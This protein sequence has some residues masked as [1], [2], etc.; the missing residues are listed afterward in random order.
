VSAQHITSKNDLNGVVGG[1]SLA[2][3]EADSHSGDLV[4]RST[5][6]GGSLVDESLGEVNGELDVR[7]IFL[8]GDHVLHLEVA[9]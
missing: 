1:V 7:Y 3:D 5:G 9:H 2:N 8:V 4:D 6:P